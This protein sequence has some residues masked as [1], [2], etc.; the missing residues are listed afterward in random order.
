MIK[1]FK[2]FLNENVSPDIISDLESILLEINDE[3]Y[4][5][6]VR[7]IN[8]IKYPENIAIDIC[9]EDQKKFDIIEIKDTLLRLRN[10]MK[11]NG[12]FS[13]MVDDASDWDNNKIVASKIMKIKNMKF[14]RDIDIII[15]DEN[16]IRYKHLFTMSIYFYEDILLESKIGQTDISEE[17]PELLSNLTDDGYFIKI[18]SFFDTYLPNVKPESMLNGDTS[19]KITIDK[20]ENTRT[21]YLYDKDSIPFQWIDIRPEIERM[22]EFLSDRYEVSS[23]SLYKVKKRDSEFYR[24]DNGKFKKHD[25]YL[26]YDDFHGRGEST[27]GRVQSDT[28]KF[29]RIPR[30]GT[31]NMTIVFFEMVINLKGLKYEI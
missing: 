4:E 7:L 9:R 21:G 3:G 30:I 31:D 27:P 15:F 20:R 19:I 22:V 26:R 5:S 2:N 1:K 29:D 6:E 18:H 14:N 17:I 10:Y 25:D 12:Y 28:V 8:N 13:N 16:S 24:T 11:L 23:I